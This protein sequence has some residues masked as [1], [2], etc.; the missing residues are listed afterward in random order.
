MSY[1]R[2]LGTALVLAGSA[3][4]APL[5]QTAP[6]PVVAPIMQKDSR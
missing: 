4:L 1:L 2:I 5:A 3:P 6:Q